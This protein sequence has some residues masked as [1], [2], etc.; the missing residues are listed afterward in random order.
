MWEGSPDPDYAHH[1]EIGQDTVI[2]VW[3]PLPQMRLRREQ[4][5]G[6]VVTHREAG[7]G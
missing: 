4:V 6:W 2:G 1:A 5:V 7:T 3:R